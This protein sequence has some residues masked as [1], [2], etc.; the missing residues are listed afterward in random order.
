MTRKQF[1]FSIALFTMLSC[2]WIY[3]WLYYPPLQVKQLEIPVSFFPS[4]ARYNNMRPLSDALP[5]IDGGIQAVYWSNGDGRAVLVIE[6]FPIVSLARRVQ[7]HYEGSSSYPIYTN[8]EDKLYQSTIAVQSVTG[9]GISELGGG[10]QCVY[11]ARYREYVVRLNVIIDGSM[12][13]EQFNTIAEYIDV[14]FQ[15]YLYD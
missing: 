12:D 15:S 3:N 4:D 10:F 6:R 13:I 5:A 7:T 9:C 14:N 2:G 8:S 1:A 11:R